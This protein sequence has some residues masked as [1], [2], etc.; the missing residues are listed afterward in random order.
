[1]CTALVLCA[2]RRAGKSRM[3]GVR[4]SRRAPREFAM[5]DLIVAPHL[6]SGFGPAIESTESLSLETHAGVELHAND[7]WSL[8]HLSDIRG[9]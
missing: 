5:A 2:I 1:M 6:R 9:L 8:V 4:N 3:I 7:R